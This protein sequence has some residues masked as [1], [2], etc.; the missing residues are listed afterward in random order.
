MCRWYYFGFR[1]R[2]LRIFWRGSAVLLRLVFVG[3]NAD[4]GVVCVDIDTQSGF[5][6]GRAMYSCVLGGE[7]L[8]RVATRKVAMHLA[9][10]GGARLLSADVSA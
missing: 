7:A 3:S 1:S 8:V 2:W 4:P 10:H 9:R 6:F 5:F